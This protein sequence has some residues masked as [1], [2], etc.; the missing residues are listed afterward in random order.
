MRKLVES[1]LA[2]LDGVIGSPDRWSLFDEESSRW[3]LQELDNYEAF[4]M[5]RVTYEFFRNS[6]GSATGGPLSER[7]NAMPKYVASRTLSEA[8][9]NATL[10]GPDPVG[11][12][13]QLKAQP[14][15]DLIKW[16]LSRLDHTLL[17]AALIDELQ[18]WFMPVVVGAG[19]RLFEDVDASSV[20]FTLTHVREF[21]NGSVIHTY[22]PS[23]RDEPHTEIRERLMRD[24]PGYARR[25]R[26][27][28]RGRRQRRPDRAGAASHAC[29]PARSARA[30]RAVGQRLPLDGILQIAALVAFAGAALTNARS[31]RGLLCRRSRRAHCHPAP[32]SGR[33]R[34]DRPAD[35][36]RG[37]RRRPTGH[38]GRPRSREAR[39]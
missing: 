36:P 12:I 30:R 32:S 39:D 33:H 13:E 27:S 38:R 18:V 9:W 15:R 17:R 19:Q 2:S 21:T 14:G 26:A 31:A 20:A 11:A 3:T 10:L 29:W 28:D 37:P 25:S 16:G 22:T 6:W 34:Q 23:Y 8:T 35:C 5:G 4:L 24:G 7:I 1:T